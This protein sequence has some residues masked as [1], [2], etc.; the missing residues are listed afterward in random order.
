MK[1]GDT[2]VVEFDR[3]TVEN[4]LGTHVKLVGTLAGEKIWLL[5]PE[6]LCRVLNSSQMVIEKDREFAQLSLGFDPDDVMSVAGLQ[7]VSPN[8][9]G[10]NSPE[11]PAVSFWMRFFNRI[12]TRK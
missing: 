7:P 3:Y 10:L 8:S 2:V 11:A 6:K 12:I 4:F 9:F 1:I 5:V